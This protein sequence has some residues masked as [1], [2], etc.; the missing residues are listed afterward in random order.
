[1]TIYTK[2]GDKGTTLL[3]K[4]G[5]VPKSHAYVHVVGHVEELIAR[6]GSACAH[7]KAGSDKLH[8]QLTEIQTSLADIISITCGYSE[9]YPTADKLENWIDEIDKSNVKSL[10]KPAE[11]GVITS[12]E[13][14]IQLCR[15]QTRTLERTIVEYKI[16]PLMLYLN[17]LG[18]YFLATARLI[19]STEILNVRTP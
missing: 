17:R 14:A 18:D 6:I 13:A 9:K 2:I 8:K 19:N 7:L 15:T 16:T 12:L 4:A 10:G 3:G 1:M 5:K 11:L